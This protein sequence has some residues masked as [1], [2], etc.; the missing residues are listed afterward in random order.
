MSRWSTIRTR[1]ETVRKHFE[2]AKR[3]SGASYW[4]AKDDAPEW[5][6]DFCREA[7]GTD[8]LPDDYRYECIVDALDAIAD[9]E[10]EESA[11]ESME[12][13]VDCGYHAMAQWLGSNTQRF[14]Y[15]DEAASDFGPFAEVDKMIQAGQLRERGEVFGQTVE[16]LGSD[17]DLPLPDEDEDEDA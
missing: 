14:G 2:Q 17:L 13:G 10:D 4:R 12:Q 16:A 5:M 7:H 15:C 11:R 8:M 1:A 9:C 6:G 3:D